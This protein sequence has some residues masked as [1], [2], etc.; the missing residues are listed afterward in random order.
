MIRYIIS[1]DLTT[2]FFLVLLAFTF[3]IEHRYKRAAMTSYS[4]KTYAQRASLH[5]N[6]VAR[7]FFETAEAKK[8][9]LI[10]SADLGSTA[11]LLQCADGNYIRWAGEYQSCD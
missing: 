10:V 8:S 6:E 7:R 11:E 3:L 1:R 9:N 4:Q 2:I 5:P